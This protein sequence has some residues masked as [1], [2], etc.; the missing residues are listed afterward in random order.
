[1]AG[2]NTQ[3]YGIK[4]WRIY[5]EPIDGEAV[6]LSYQ[7]IKDRLIT[8]SNGTGTTLGTFY[9][10]LITSVT[11]DSNKKYNGPWYISY[12][13]ANNRVSYLAERIPVRSEIDFELYSVLDKPKYTK[14]E[15]TVQFLS[16]TNGVDLTTV[17]KAPVIYED[18]EVMSYFTPAIKINWPTRTLNNENGTRAYDAVC[19]PTKPNELLGYSYGVAYTSGDSNSGISCWCRGVGNISS[20]NLNTIT[21]F[22]KVKLTTEGEYVIFQNIKIS[23]LP[24]SYMYY[25]QFYK[26]GRYEFSYGEGNTG[27]FGKGVYIPNTVKYVVNA[28][29][30]YYWGLS[31]SVPENEVQIKSKNS[32]LLNNS[33]FTNGTTTSTVVGEDYNC[34][35]FWVAFPPE[36]ALVSYNNDIRIKLEQPDG[37]CFDLVSETQTMKLKK[38]VMHLGDNSTLKEYN[39]AYF[40]FEHPIG[41]KSAVVSFRIVPQEEIRVICNLNLE[42]GVGIEPEKEDYD[43]FRTESSNNII[44]DDDAFS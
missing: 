15:I 8:N 4:N 39:V 25:P 31:D 7:D 9:G 23:Y 18:V 27:W 32:G 36:F 19:N 40:E 14:P 24:A 34:T 2:A 43:I 1:M 22:P 5:R 29:W 38:M 30:K 21:Y 44:Y 12:N 16:A 26:N 10:G 6:H 11:S 37:I 20:Y 28:R 41:N 42:N 3:Q 17:S 35:S 13:I 33:T